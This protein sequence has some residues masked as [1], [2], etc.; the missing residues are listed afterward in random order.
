M[1]DI[2]WSELVVIAVV[3]IVVIGPKDLPRA[4]RTVG[5]WTA[6]MKGMAREFQNQF[7]EAMRE[8]ELD[9]VKKDVEDLA[10]INPMADLKKD[11]GKVESDVRAS[12]SEP[13]PAAPATPALMTGPQPAPATAPNGANPPPPAIAP[14]ANG[15]EPAATPP[16]AA[17]VAEA[18]SAPVTEKPVAVAEGGTP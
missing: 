3:A 15:A 14:S 9:G 18:S 2:G 13:K 6:K 16:P 11:L 5:R 17:A 7:N 10:K 12:L 8:A 4:M 1:F